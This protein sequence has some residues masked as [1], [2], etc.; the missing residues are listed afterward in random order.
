MGTTTKTK[1]R[2]AIAVAVLGALVLGLLPAAGALTLG[3]DRLVPCDQVR[4]LDAVL[5]DGTHVDGP[6]GGGGCVVPTSG[7]WGFAIILAAVPP[8]ALLAKL[9]RTKAGDDS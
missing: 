7:A 8:V 6:E 2:P 1:D 4:G 5:D 3:G 9:A